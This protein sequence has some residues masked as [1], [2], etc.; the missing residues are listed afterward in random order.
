MVEYMTQ[1]K[2]VFVVESAVINN[3]IITTWQRVYQLRSLL[4]YCYYWHCYC[5][6]CCCQAYHYHHHHHYY[7]YWTS[8]GTLLLQY[9]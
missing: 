6:D 2:G 1:Q 9:E 3:N 7:C 5:R 4:V 8:R